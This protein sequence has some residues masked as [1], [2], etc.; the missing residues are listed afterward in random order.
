MGN[1]NGSTVLHLDIASIPRIQIPQLSL[2]EQEEIATTLSIYDNLFKKLD[3]QIILSQKL[4]QG[5][6]N[7]IF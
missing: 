3:K 7:E 6:I 2:I 1:S 5:L 4:K